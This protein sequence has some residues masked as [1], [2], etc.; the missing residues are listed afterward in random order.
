MVPL[1]HSMWSDSA[2][3]CLIVKDLDKKHE[4]TVDMTEELL[5]EHQVTGITKVL[6]LDQL[7]KEHKGKS[8]I[9]KSSIEGH[10]LSSM[11]IT[12]ISIIPIRISSISI[13]KC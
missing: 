3:K 5:K 8:F 10:M 12:N 1:V 4:D 7:K 2:T 11:R 6:P 13:R 9:T